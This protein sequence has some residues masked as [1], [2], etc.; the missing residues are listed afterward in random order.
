MIP[1]FKMNLKGAK[2]SKNTPKGRLFQNIPKYSKMFQNIPKYSKII[3]T[4]DE[5]KASTKNQH[6]YV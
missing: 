1:N 4:P 2:L 3:Q 5:F 6:K